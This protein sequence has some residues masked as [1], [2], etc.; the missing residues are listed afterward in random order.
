MKLTTFTSPFHL[1]LATILLLEVSSAFSLYPRREHPARA[2][3][4]GVTAPG[5]L[6]YPRSAPV[7]V[8]KSAKKPQSSPTKGGP[9]GGGSTPPKNNP[10]ATAP[11][12]NN[13]K[14]IV[15][16][17]PNSK[18]WCGRTPGVAPEGKK[19]KIPANAVKHPGSKQFTTEMIKKTLEVAAKMQFTNTQL[20]T[21]NARYPKGFSNENRAAGSKG[22]QMMPG[23]P[24]KMFEFPIMPDGNPSGTSP[25][26]YTYEG[27]TERPQHSPGETILCPKHKPANR[28]KNQPKNDPKNKPNKQQAAATKKKEAKKAKQQAQTGNWKQR[29]KEKKKPGAALPKPVQSNK[30]PVGGR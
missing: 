24:A 17:P 21:P 5:P 10:K 13:Q 19:A 2:L 23:R 11:K 1:L 25:Q 15:V 3:V 20:R 28:S 9:P 4:G 8:Q 6:I 22:G 26:V 18:A 12:N 7:P 16:V 14:Y 27:M 29:M 30:K